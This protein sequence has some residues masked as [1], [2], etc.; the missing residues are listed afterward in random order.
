MRADLDH[1]NEV[2]ALDSRKL[3]VKTRCPLAPSEGPT[4]MAMDQRHKRLFIGC[5]NK[6]M[7][8][9]DADHGHVVAALP[10]GSGVDATAFDPETKLA[11]S[12]NGEGT[13]TVVHED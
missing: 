13:L 7:I 4:G 3:L 2:V 9:M 8:V 5:G 10:I 6:K 12:S 1:K 11:F